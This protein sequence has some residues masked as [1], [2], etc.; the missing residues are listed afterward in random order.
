MK[1][2]LWRILGALSLLIILSGSVAIAA[3]QDEMTPDF[4]CSQ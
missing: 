1:R 4:S 2:N 3:A